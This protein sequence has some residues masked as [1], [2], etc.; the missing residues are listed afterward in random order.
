VR[1]RKEEEVASCSAEG[2]EEVRAMGEE[3]QEEEELEE[4][5]EEEAWGSLT[6][7]RA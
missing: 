5:A 7:D 1:S 2:R 4:E 3:E 6:R